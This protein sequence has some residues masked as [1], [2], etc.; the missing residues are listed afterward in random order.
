MNCHS[1][2]RALI[3]FAFPK[4]KISFSTNNITFAVVIYNEH[5]VSLKSLIFKMSVFC[6]SL[7]Q[8][9]ARGGGGV[10]W[11]KRERDDRRKS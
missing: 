7:T 6:C 1:Q 4:V 8:L 10:L 3:L 11:G 5:V 9:I 2:T